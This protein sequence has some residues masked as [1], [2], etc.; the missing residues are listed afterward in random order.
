MLAREMS[1]VYF[2]RVLNSHLILLVVMVQQAS[3][4][5]IILL[6]QCHLQT[7]IFRVED[8]AVEFWART[9]L[10]RLERVK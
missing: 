3:L 6:K 5:G 9:V 10:E 8:L 4:V 1:T 7:E 2:K